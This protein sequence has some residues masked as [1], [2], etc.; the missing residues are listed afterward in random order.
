MSTKFIVHLTIFLCFGQYYVAAFDPSTCIQCRQSH[1]CNPPDCF[2]CRDEMPLETHNIPQMVF[3]SF[4][5]AVN[6]QV[7]SY[8]REL[9][10]AKRKNPNGCPISM[11]L[12]I[13][14]QNTV[15]S[16]V[17]E[18]YDKGMEIASHSV[19]HSHP[20]PETFARE[21]KAQKENL[22]QQA[23]IP[24]TKITGWRSPFLEP[25]GDTQP[26]VLKDLGYEYDATLTIT[27]RNE[28][29][30]PVT[31]FTL[32]FGWPYDCKIKPCPVREHKGFWEVPVV[33][34]KDY[35]NKYDCVYIDGCNNPPPSQN[36]AFKFL[37]DNFQKYY[38]TNRAPMGI[39]M[40]ASW[41][42]YPDR[43]AAMDKF[44]Q[45]LVQMD[46]V[47]IVTIKQVI[48][49]LKHP[50]PLHLIKDFQPWTCHG[51][52]TTTSLSALVTPVQ[53]SQ[54][55]SQESFNQ[56]RQFQSELTDQQ[57][58]V[59][60]TSQPTMPPS[61]SPTPYPTRETSWS[62]PQPQVVPPIPMPL[63]QPPLVP[64]LPMVRFWWGPPSIL[65]PK[66]IEMQKH[67]QI[68]KAIQEQNRHDALKARQ[69]EEERLKRKELQRQADEKARLLEEQKQFEIAREKERLRQL[70]L[71]RQRLEAETL[72]QIENQRKAE[73][74]AKLL[75]EK[76]IQEQRQQDLAKEQERLRQ[77]EAERQSQLLAKELETKRQQE[78]ERHKQETERRLQILKQKEI[79]RQMQLQLQKNQELEQ[80][81]IALE[82]H[83]Q[84]EARQREIQRQREMERQQHLLLMQDIEMKKTQQ[85][86]VLTPATEQFIRTSAPI[87][88][89]ITQPSL[90][91]TDFGKG[92]S[93][94]LD[95]ILQ[96]QHGRRV[97]QLEQLS[98]DELKALQME[99]R[100]RLLRHRNMRQQN[101]QTVEQVALTDNNGRQLEILLPNKDHPARGIPDIYRGQEANSKLNYEKRMVM[102]EFHT[103]AG[104]KRTRINK[105][106]I[107]SDISKDITKPESEFKSRT[108]VPPSLISTAEDISNFSVET[109]AEMQSGRFSD[110]IE[111]PA[112]SKSFDAPLEQTV[113][114]S[115][116]QPMME[117]SMT[118]ASNTSPIASSTY[119]PMTTPLPSTTASTMPPSTTTTS[120]TTTTAATTVATTTVDSTVVTSSTTTTMQTNT[121]T[122][123]PSTTSASLSSTITDTTVVS[124]PSITTTPYQTTTTTP[125][126]DPRIVISQTSYQPLQTITTSYVKPVWNMEGFD[127]L[128]ASFQQLMNRQPNNQIHSFTHST[129][130]PTTKHAR[131]PAIHTFFNLYDFNKVEQV[132]ERKSTHQ[133]LDSGSSIINTE[134]TVTTQAPI[135]PSVMNAL[136]SD[137]RFGGRVQQQILFQTPSAMPARY[138]SQIQF[139]G[140]VLFSTKS[141]TQ[142]NTKRTSLTE[143]ESAQ[144]TKN[145]YYLGSSEKT[146]KQLSVSR[147]PLTQSNTPVMSTNEQLQSVC[148]QGINCIAPNCVCKTESTP[149]GLKVK[150][151]P[152]IIYIT[153]DGSLNFHSYSK[154]KSLFTQSRVNPN[155]CKIGGTIFVSDT[156]SSYR[157]ADVLRSDGIEMALMGLDPRP[158][159]NATKI[160]REILIQKERIMSSSA[161]LENDIRGWK[162][163]SYKPAGD[164][165][166]EILSN[167]SMYDSSLVADRSASGKAK[168]W[169]FTLDFGWEEKCEIETCPD[170]KHPG[171]WEVPIIPFLGIDE[172]AKCDVT[173]GCPRQP[174]SAK[175]TYDYLMNN[176]N[177]Y[178]K[179]NKAPFAIRLKQIW[180]HWFYR[181]NMDGLLKFLDTVLSYKDVY[182]STIS[183]M[184]EWIKSPVLLN[185]INSFAP[186]RC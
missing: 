4:D 119:L 11:T 114:S 161:F 55:I 124:T 21:A 154:M 13:S 24:I 69:I 53:Q 88:N 50:T 105:N 99:L 73:Q 108:I 61:R 86:L 153:L 12:F 85:A 62:M 113:T 125:T 10:D 54:Q 34:V 100:N 26:S 185:D 135:S 40:H 181:E 74:Q 43:K 116:H 27:P 8:Y 39:N 52:N 107:K 129:E 80:Q 29:D 143:T 66:E 180:F 136:N 168:L 184:L 51:D 141:P 20:S 133:I 49:W 140:D 162:S 70:D 148:I 152:Q 121:T 183:D 120:T 167:L 132:A 139:D 146:T 56:K 102:Q 72:L 31:P 87:S 127:A 150:D 159:S 137:F 58:R 22:A 35:L 112:T 91:S 76:R 178:Y 110:F 96:H 6:P 130:Q 138:S 160:R 81:R 89:M 115:A 97:H 37:W 166:F 186:W 104:V 33:S 98:L 170:E 177:Q 23:G 147:Q 149:H 14:H 156:G 16:I 19:T 179:T 131:P 59:Q 47:Y 28:K 36:L 165:Q 3:F 142:A 144:I 63:P 68:Q 82:R 71:E 77:Q 64:N 169:P 173:D 151:I 171:V 38:T 92:I 94:K 9:F 134:Q 2:C 90:Q 41:F 155:G 106:E 123:I 172:G 163:P 103:S 5:D 67:L 176:F 175:E 118:L 157:I 46:D 7:A 128:P 126:I 83:N 18:F 1:M 45:K 48:E 75:E 93:G 158:E 32:D 25:L 117:S 164:A 174:T 42:Y 57:R 15:Y 79:E 65:S 78:A 17:R 44:I 145:P 30:K 111:L 84:E 109:V 95:S 101:E 122:D 182:A 60:P